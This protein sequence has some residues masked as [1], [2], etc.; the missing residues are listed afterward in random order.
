MSSETSININTVIAIAIVVA[1]V[2]F[3][4]VLIKVVRL[5]NELTIT[6][7]KS[8]TTMDNLDVVLQDV[9]RTLQNVD[10]VVGD[11]HHKYFAMN[12]SLTKSLDFISGAVTNILSPKGDK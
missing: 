4:L 9:S 6:V 2:V 3:I 8:H 7:K 11:L 10:P 12:E 1:L 5:L